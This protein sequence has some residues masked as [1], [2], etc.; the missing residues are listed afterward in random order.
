MLKKIEQVVSTWAWKL[1]MP[2]IGALLIG[3]LTIVLNQADNRVTAAETTITKTKDILLK[4]C[5]DA[6]KEIDKKLATKVDNKHFDA[7][8]GI[9]R[10]EQ[11]EQKVLNKELIETMQELKVHIRRE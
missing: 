7:L 2:V 11:K 9:I 4:H 6:P 5:N 8:I 3:L 1:V 10:E